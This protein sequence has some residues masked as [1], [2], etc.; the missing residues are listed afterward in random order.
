MVSRETPSPDQLLD[1]ADRLEHLADELV[2]PM[3]CRDPAYGAP[4]Y[5]HCAACCYGTGY[6]VT[7]PEDQ[8]LVD[9]ATAMTAAARQLRADAQQLR[10]IGWDVASHGERG[11]E[12]RWRRDPAEALALAFTLGGCIVPAGTPP[13]DTCPDCGRSILPDEPD[14][15]DF[16][17]GHI[18]ATCVIPEVTR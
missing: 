11:L 12:L 14:G 2:D 8:Q 4:G 3:V 10:P 18:H 16:A 9:T 7:C 13:P 17:R 6:V 15:Y 5:D 1:L